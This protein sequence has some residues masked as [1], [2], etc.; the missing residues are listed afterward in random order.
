VGSPNAGKKALTLQTLPS[1]AEQRLSLASNAN[2]IV[3]LKSPYSDGTTHVVL[4]PLEF[5]A[6][7]CRWPRRPRTKPRANLTRFHGVYSWGG[8]PPNS[9]LRKQIVPE[10]LILAEAGFNPAAHKSGLKRYG[11]FW[12]QRLKRVFNGAAIR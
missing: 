9:K 10:K 8:L 3:E 6:G 7:W 2:V 11:M 12:A 5:L 4:G 1:I